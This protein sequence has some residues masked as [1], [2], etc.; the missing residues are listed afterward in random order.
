MCVLIMGSL[1]SSTDSIIT[2]IEIWGLKSFFIYYY[3]TEKKTKIFLNYVISRTSY[4]CLLCVDLISLTHN[5][6]TLAGRYL[7]IKNMWVIIF[8]NILKSVICQIVF[9]ILTRKYRVQ[10]S[11]LKIQFALLC[12]CM[13]LRMRINMG[14]TSC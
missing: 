13:T 2:I 10:C 8:I 5:I 7:Y 6:I 3:Q 14:I 12:N 9:F 4:P 11:L 1:V